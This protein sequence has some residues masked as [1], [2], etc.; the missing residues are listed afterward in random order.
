M[1]VSAS[2]SQPRNNQ[3]NCRYM[4]L[5]NKLHFY[6]VSSQWSPLG[7]T[8]FKHPSCTANFCFSFFSH[9][10]KLAEGLAEE[11]RAA[12]PSFSLTSPSSGPLLLRGHMAVF[13]F[14]LF[15]GLFNSSG[16][17]GIHIFCSFGLTAWLFSDQKSFR[18][19]HPKRSGNNQLVTQA[20]SDH[21]LRHSVLT[22]S[23]PPPS[24]VL[25]CWIYYSFSTASCNLD[26]GSFRWLYR[27]LQWFDK[28]R[29]VKYN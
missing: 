11:N 7:L 4:R 21:P 8:T 1:C 27:W 18:C 23:H 3:L 17:C 29:L 6:N 15:W 9:C 5:S 25:P 10:W 20:P 22:A 26:L 16:Y 2:A 14:F 13:L 24:H 28:H 12:L 19:S